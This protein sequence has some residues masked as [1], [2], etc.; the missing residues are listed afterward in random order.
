MSESPDSDL[1]TPADASGP[2]PAGPGVRGG[3][4]EES[5]RKVEEQFERLVSGVR[6]YAI[7]LLDPGG[8]RR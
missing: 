2:E 1:P 8:A 4:G 3:P 6:D 7:F 5:L